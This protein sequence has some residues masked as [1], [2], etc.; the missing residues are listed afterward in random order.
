MSSIEESKVRNPY[1]PKENKNGDDLDGLS[2]SISDSA[3]YSDGELFLDDKK[4]QPK[5]EPKVEQKP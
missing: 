3:S 1:G 5:P 2:D 4:T